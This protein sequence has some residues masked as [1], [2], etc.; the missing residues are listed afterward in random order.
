MARH[1]VERRVRCEP[2]GSPPRLRTAIGLRFVEL[3]WVTGDLTFLQRGSH[4]A[5]PTDSS[6][7]SVRRPMRYDL[8]RGI[9]ADAPR[10]HGAGPLEALTASAL[11]TRTDA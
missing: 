2:G 1:M 9:R 5:R 4:G 6:R 7:R 8:T 3:G 11:G 10:G